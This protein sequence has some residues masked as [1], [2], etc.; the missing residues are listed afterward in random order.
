V[1]IVGMFISQ[2]S[3]YRCILGGAM[4]YYYDPGQQDWTGVL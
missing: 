1:V 3:L 2:E 4:R